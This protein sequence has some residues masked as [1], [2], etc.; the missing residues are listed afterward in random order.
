MLIAKIPIFITARGNT[1][2]V[3]ET[4][5]EA[6]KFSYLFIKNLNLFSQT[7]IISDSKKMLEWASQLGFIN[8]IYYPCGNEKDLLYLEYLATYRYGVENEYHPDWIIIL[9]INQIFK[10][11]SL[12]RDCINSIDDKYDVIASYTQISNKSKFFVD[13]KLLMKDNKTDHLLSSNHHRV[14][15]VDAAIYAI[16]TTFAFECMEYDDPSEHFWKGKI[17]FFQNNSLY[18][19]IFCLDDIYKYYETADTIEKVKNIEKEINIK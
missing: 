6:L 10:Q 8:T 1:E 4:N 7:Y 18:T 17:K 19:D 16:K 15:M 9:N 11:V 2:E 13:E 14:K 5:K 3:F 12:L